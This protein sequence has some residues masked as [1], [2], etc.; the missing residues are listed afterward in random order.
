MPQLP[1]CPSIDEP[2]GTATILV[3]LHDGNYQFAAGKPDGSDIRFVAADDKSPLAFHIE[4][5]DSLLNEAFVWVKLPEIKPAGQTKFWL[6]YGNASEKVSPVEES[7]A[8]FDAETVLAY[9]F[10]ENGTAPVDFSAGGNRAENAGVAVGGSLIGGGLRLTG[11][12]RVTIP[13][14]ASLEWKA[15]ATGS[16][17]AWVKPSSLSP[18]AL[19]L[20]RRDGQS[21]MLL[22]LDDGVPYVEISAAGSTQRSAPGEPLAPNAWRHLSVV[23]EPSKTTLYIN[24]ETY[25]TIPLGV[26]ALNSTLVLGREAP[27]AGADPGSAV[28][29]FAGEVD[30]LR[31]SRGGCP[32]GLLKLDSMLQ[33]ATD[34]AG[35]V[36][37]SGK[38]EES[39]GGGNSELAEHLSLFKEISHSLTFDGWVVIALCAILAVVGWA[40]TLSKFFYLNKIKK[41][42]EAFRSEWDKISSDLTALDHS[43]ATTIRSMGGNVNSSAQKL[44]RESPLFHIYQLG[45]HEISR[46]LSNAREGVTGLSERSIHAIRVTLDGGLFREIQGLNRNIVFLTIGIAGGPYLGLLGTVI[47]VMITFA[48]I[49]KSGEVEINSIAPGI[50]GALLATVAGLAVAIPALFAYSYISARIKDAIGEMQNFIE[51][52]VAKMAEFYPSSND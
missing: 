24:G 6:Y 22:G 39:G 4:R 17:S 36:L 41:S 46:R 11:Q 26:P 44:M 20:S 38:D 32:V 33:S 9:H 28:L 27:A 23:F 12:N 37:Q 47:G 51:E 49:A 48:V 10:S 7:K 42:S 2:I 29:G 8:S 31:L 18:K 40:V 45:S 15:G 3:R 14:S 50:A 5:F 25:A 16:I 21:A 34:Q 30:E 13:A 35:K 43:D 52:F 19:L 1:E